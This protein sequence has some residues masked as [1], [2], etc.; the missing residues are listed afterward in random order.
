M[1]NTCHTGTMSQMANRL[2]Q[3]IG[4]RWFVLVGVMGLANPQSANVSP[5]YSVCGSVIQTMKL[6]LFPN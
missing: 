2:K 3:R 4:K 5:E 1:T 6:K